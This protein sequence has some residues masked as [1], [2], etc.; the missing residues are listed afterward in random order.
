MDLFY[1]FISDGAKTIDLGDVDGVQRSQGKIRQNLKSK[2]SFRN[3]Y[4]KKCD[5]IDDRGNQLQREK[6]Q[7]LGHANDRCEREM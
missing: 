5:K 3:S 6:P 2:K 7:R 4:R 1:I